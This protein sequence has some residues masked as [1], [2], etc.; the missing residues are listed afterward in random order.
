[1][2]DSTFLLMHYGWSGVML[3]VIF[4]RVWASVRSDLSFYILYYKKWFFWSKH[5]L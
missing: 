5:R 4:G 2:K 3:I 1:V